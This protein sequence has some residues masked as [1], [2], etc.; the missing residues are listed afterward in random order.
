MSEMHTQ[1]HVIECYKH[2]FNSKEG[3]VVLDNLSRAHKLYD[4]SYS[5]DVN[6]KGDPLAMAYSEGQRMV[7]LTIL[8]MLSS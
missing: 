3:Q 4:T 6:G 5:S 1:E 2:V 8:A 7:V